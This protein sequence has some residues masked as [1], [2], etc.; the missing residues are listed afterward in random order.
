VIDNQTILQTILRQTANRASAVRTGTTNQTSN[1][2]SL[3]A[4]QQI[5]DSIERL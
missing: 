2:F 1:N 4:Q 5:I 3:E